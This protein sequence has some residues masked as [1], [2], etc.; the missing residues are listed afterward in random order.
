MRR[1]IAGLALTGVMAPAAAGASEVWAGAYA[2]D[3][4]TPLTFSGFEPGVDLQLGWRGERIEGWRGVGR[5]SPYVF[6]SVNTA[7]A[8]NFA[9][10][11]LSWT[12]GDRV[13]FRPGLGLAIHD[14]PDDFD[15]TG[16]RI[17]FGSR[18]V[19]EPELAVGWRVSDRL[20]VDASWV[21]L[22]HAQLLSRQNPGMD[23]FGVRVN[24]R[25]GGR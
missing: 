22:S 1:V 16:E 15:P 18:V 19:F 6:A 12:F 25:T 4:K 13:Y 17:Y 24:Y 11:G 5:P 14:G 8:T 3:V 21:H 9:A 20:S 2:H 10:A 7:G 23:A